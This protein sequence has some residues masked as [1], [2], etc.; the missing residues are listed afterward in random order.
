[1]RIIIYSNIY[2][3]YISAGASPHHPVAASSLVNEPEIIGGVFSETPGA[4]IDA[5]V[6][7]QDKNVVVDQFFNPIDLI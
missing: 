3:P 2:A 6:S 4:N 5:K 7:N 1:L